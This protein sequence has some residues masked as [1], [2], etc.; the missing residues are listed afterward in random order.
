M[1]IFKYFL[2]VGLSLLGVIIGYEALMVAQ[3]TSQAR[4]FASTASTSLSVLRAM[5]H[6]GEYD[7]PAIAAAGPLLP[8]NI[9]ATTTP[10]ADHTP[11]ASVQPTAPV[12][13]SASPSALNARAQISHEAVRPSKSAKKKVAAVRK[14]RPRAVYVENMQRGAFGFFG[15]VQSW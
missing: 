8:F 11:V 5:A 10:D 7:R 13:Q 12:L 9:P 2:L 6:H 3:P 1:P 4:P 14:P 15:A